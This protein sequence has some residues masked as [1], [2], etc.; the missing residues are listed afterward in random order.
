[1]DI[2]DIAEKESGKKAAAAGTEQ[3]AKEV[4]KQEVDFS[5]FEFMRQIDIAVKAKVLDRN[6][7]HLLDHYIVHQHKTFH[8]L[9]KDQ[10]VSNHIG[11]CLNLVR[12]RRVK[13]KDL[14]IIE[15]K[16]GSKGFYIKV[17]YQ[18]KYEEDL[19]TQKMG[20][21]KLDT[22]KLSTQDLSA[23]K[24]STQNQYTILMSKLDQRVDQINAVSDQGVDLSNEREE[25]GGA[26]AEPHGPAFSESAPKKTKTP[27]FMAVDYSEEDPAPLPEKRG[28]P[29]K[30]RKQFIPP[31]KE[32]IR[33]EL[34][35]LLE[36]KGTFQQW[37]DNDLRAMT[38]KFFDWYDARDWKKNHGQK[39]KDWRAALNTTWLF[40]QDYLP[41]R[42]TRNQPQREGKKIWTADQIM[43]FAGDAD[44][45]RALEQRR[46]QEIQKGGVIIAE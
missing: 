20:T 30:E 42:T 37:S 2:A 28:K 31:T 12:E 23:Q 29:K 18:W 38:D 27:P 40:K 44:P 5:L 34:E 41:E 9:F 13:L 39:L 25:E 32:E 22:Q 16:Q 24:L 11:I 36:K 46:E 19:S 45:Q 4:K 35:S 14:K 8:Y 15:T 21:Q 10:T 33:L 43:K 7:R 26:T 3:P 17:C 1:M 6:D